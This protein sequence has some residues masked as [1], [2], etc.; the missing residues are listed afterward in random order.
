[1]FREQCTPACERHECA[2]CWSRL[3]SQ[4]TDL[5]VTFNF[6][7]VQEGAITGMAG[8]A[9]NVVRWQPAGGVERVFS[10]HEKPP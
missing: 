4:I 8:E 5:A 10:D 6:V 1:M 2:A 7:S 3:G 9:L